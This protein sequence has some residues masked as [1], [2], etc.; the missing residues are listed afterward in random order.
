MVFLQKKINCLNLVTFCMVQ[1]QKETPTYLLVILIFFSEKGYP[2]KQCEDS[3]E[4]V[5]IY[6][7]CS[8]DHIGKLL[9][10]KYLK[11]M[12]LPCQY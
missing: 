11:L 9:I 4:E 12:H 2:R 6:F 1:V 8:S 5:P 10:I 3:F 7:D